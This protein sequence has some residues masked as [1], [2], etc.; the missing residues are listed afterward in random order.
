MT[1]SRWVEMVV[2]AAGFSPFPLL[3]SPPFFGSLPN[4]DIQRKM[5][6]AA[7]LPRR[8]INNSTPSRKADGGRRERNCALVTSFQTP[9]L[10]INKFK[11]TRVKQGKLGSWEKVRNE[12][13]PVIFRDMNMNQ[14][15]SIHINNHSHTYILSFQ[16][17]R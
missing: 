12:N 7:T 14:N 9:P 2:T 11:S 16:M 15:K 3:L 13:T 4:S 10:Q 5:I 17:A 8:L 6:T 1:W